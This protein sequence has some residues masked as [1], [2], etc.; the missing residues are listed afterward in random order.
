LA[1]DVEKPESDRLRRPSHANRLAHRIRRFRGAQIGYP[2]DH[3][4]A[5][6][7]NAE[8]LSPEVNPAA[9]FCAGATFFVH[10][11]RGLWIANQDRQLSHCL[12]AVHH[13]TLLGTDRHILRYYVYRFRQLFEPSMTGIDNVGA[14]FSRGAPL[15]AIDQGMA[16]NIRP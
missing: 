11:T 12:F 5:F 1:V 9:L 14:L 4:P 10:W 6:I 15:A 7:R 13:R 16:A 2:D 8:E 3:G